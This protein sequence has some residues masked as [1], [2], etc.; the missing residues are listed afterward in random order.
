[1]SR[2]GDVNASLTKWQRKLTYRMDT[3]QLAVLHYASRRRIT[4]VN[5]HAGTGKTTL[6]AAY[7]RLMIDLHRTLERIMCP[8][9][10]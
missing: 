1:M 8:L 4:A 9:F 7:T 10:H 5:G 3:D 2:T 6:V